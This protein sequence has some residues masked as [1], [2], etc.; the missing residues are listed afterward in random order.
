MTTTT[1]EAT[2]REQ[3]VQ[4]VQRD[5]NLSSEAKAKDTVAAVLDALTGIVVEHS[6]EPG[7][8]FRVH[9]IGTFKVV[10]QKARDRR[11]PKDGTSVHFDARNKVVLKLAKNLRDLGK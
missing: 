5:L 6:N 10:A 4:R 11:N 1:T 8:S 3:L 9:E 2:L 7:W